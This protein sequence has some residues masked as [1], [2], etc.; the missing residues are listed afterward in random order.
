[1]PALTPMRSQRGLESGSRARRAGTCRLP[2]CCFQASGFEERAAR[3][4]FKPTPI[5]LPRVE[6]A[7]IVVIRF[8]LW[9]RLILP[10]DSNRIEYFPLGHVCCQ[11]EGTWAGEPSE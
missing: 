6:S 5:V 2:M 10:L 7:I 8:S 9:R 11:Y 1:M 3:L 4:A